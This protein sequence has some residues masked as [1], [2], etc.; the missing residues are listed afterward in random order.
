MTHSKRRSFFIIFVSILALLTIAA[1]GTVVSLTAS[2]GGG[3]NENIT[4]SATLRADSKIENSNLYFEVRA[5][6]GTVVATNSASV[7]SLD[8]GGTFSY[9]WNANNGGFPATGNYSVSVCW[10]PGGS[11]NCQIVGGPV[12]T[13]F[14]SVPTFGNLL[15]ILALVLVGAWLWHVRRQLARPQEAIA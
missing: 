8:N 3:Y 2:G 10:S 11:Q 6:D 9:S 5:P 13:S 12:T 15:G 7:P 4:I 1:N 14:Y